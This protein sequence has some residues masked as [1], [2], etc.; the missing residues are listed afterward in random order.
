M[1]DHCDVILRSDA[2]PGQLR[3]I[4]AALWR[5]CNAVEAGRDTFQC[6]DSQSL[7]DLIAGRFPTVNRPSADERD[8]RVRVCC[9][10]GLDGRVTI[11]RLRRALPRAGVTDVQVDGTSW[12]RVDSID[13]TDPTVSSA[14]VAGSLPAG[15][16]PP[17]RASVDGAPH[18]TGGVPE[19]TP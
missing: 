17:V 18:R 12:D 7:A 15:R 5:W 8:I 13:P 10:A 3:A 6:L 9:E 4:G 11:N 2:T 19:P 16:Q 14:A 1:S